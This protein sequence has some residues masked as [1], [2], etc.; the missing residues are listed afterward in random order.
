[1]RAGIW[2]DNWLR[3]DT[4]LIVNVCAPRELTLSMVPEVTRQVFAAPFNRSG[5]VSGFGLTQVPPALLLP[6]AFIVSDA[7]CAL[8]MARTRPTIAP[9][10]NCNDIQTRLPVFTVTTLIF[11]CL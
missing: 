1:M 3:Y 4:P 7:A 8:L 5:N 9:T 6:T 11:V 10:R 2:F